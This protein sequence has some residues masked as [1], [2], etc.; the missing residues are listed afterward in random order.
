[1]IFQVASALGLFAN[2]LEAGKM[3]Q[4]ILQVA[5]QLIQKGFAVGAGE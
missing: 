4:E 2:T 3:R 1:M 5:G